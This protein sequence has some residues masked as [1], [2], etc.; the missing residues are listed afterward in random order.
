LVVED[1]ESVRAVAASMLRRMGFEV[2][3]APDGQAGLALYGEHCARSPLVLMDLTMPHLDGRATVRELQ[4]SYPG[5]R[6]LLMSGYTEATAL[7]G[8]VGKGV[9]G[10]IQKPF[11]FDELEVV[12]AQ[13]LAVTRP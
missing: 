1:E 7:D 12:I 3:T 11:Q 9:L 5:A 4:R 8:L 2:L 10:F 13:A 6:V